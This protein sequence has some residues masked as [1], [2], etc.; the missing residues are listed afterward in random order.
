MVRGRDGDRKGTVRGW[1]GDGSVTVRG[2]V[3]ND[4]VIQINNL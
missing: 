3:I 1:N 2:L 4:L